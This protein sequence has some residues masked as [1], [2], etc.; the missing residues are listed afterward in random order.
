MSTLIA[1][2]MA[3]NTARAFLDPIGFSAYLGLPI[4]PGEPIGF[5]HVYALRAAFLGLFTAILIVRRD[6]GA[7]KWY[8][9]AAMIMPIGDAALVYGAG[10]PL[11]KVARHLAIALYLLITFALLH[12][13]HVKQG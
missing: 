9:L 13:T 12:R 7:L 3:V 8:A 2:F 4:A 1:V 10:G 11:D 5:V 6:L